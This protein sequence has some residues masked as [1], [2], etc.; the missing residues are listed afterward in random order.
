MLKNNIN[1]HFRFN[2]SIEKNQILSFYL[3]TRN[4]LL[5]QEEDLL[6]NLCCEYFEKNPINIQKTNK[7]IFQFNKF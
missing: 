5:T 2:P 7:F 3:F 4:N 1:F 6:H